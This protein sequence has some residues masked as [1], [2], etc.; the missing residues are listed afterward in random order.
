MQLDWGAELADL[1]IGFIPGS[2][3]VNVL[4]SY[5]DLYSEAPFPGAAFVDYT[6]TSFNSSFDYRVLSTFSWS[7]G[8]YYVGLRWQHLPS[9]IPP[10]GSAA[11]AF[12]IDS[13]DQ[14]DLFGRWSFLDRYQLRVGI[15][16]LLNAEPEIVGANATNNA[17]GAT[18][19][20]YDQIGR[21]FF[22]GLSA[23]F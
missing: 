20:T 10:P 8:P 5:L 15:D 4:A 13:H 19:S 9:V 23:S 3:S 7:D 2:F 1:G 21:R 17:R 16:N 18:N 6:G 22:V 14:V 11:T 12:G